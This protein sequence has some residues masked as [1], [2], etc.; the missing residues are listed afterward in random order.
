MSPPSQ[1][2]KKS[3]SLGLFKPKRKKSEQQGSEKSPT[4]DTTHAQ[5]M[6]NAEHREAEGVD[7]DNHIDE[8]SRD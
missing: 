2:A 1:Q 3:K 8:R 6:K 7:W 5:D 4:K